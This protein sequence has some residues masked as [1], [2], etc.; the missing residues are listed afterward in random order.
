MSGLQ[1]GKQVREA[2]VLAFAIYLRY[3]HLQND[4]ARENQ[5]FSIVYFSA[6]VAHDDLFCFARVLFTNSGIDQDHRHLERSGRKKLH[7]LLCS[8]DEQKSS[9]SL[10]HGGRY[11]QATEA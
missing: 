7:K 11:D 6:S 4:F 1:E 3:L 8:S 2:G 9:G 5:T 10:Y